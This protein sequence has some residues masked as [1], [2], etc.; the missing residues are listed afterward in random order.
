[1]LLDSVDVF[2]EVVNAQSFSR[3]AARLGIPATT[4]S[5]RIR[6][7]EE[8]LGTALLHRTTRRLSLTDAG[9]RYFAHCAQAIDLVQQAERAVATTLEEPRGRLRITAPADLAQTVLVPVIAAYQARY[10]AVEID[11]LVSNHYRDLVGEGIDLAI[12]VGE[13]RSSSLIVRRFF[14]SALGLWAAPDYLARQPGLH[15][16]ADLTQQKLV[17]MRTNRRDIV[18]RDGAE[19]FA[20]DSMPGNLQLDDML[21]CQAFAEGGLGIAL[22]PLFCQTSVGD[23]AR[24]VRVLPHVQTEEFPVNFLYPRQNLVPPTVRAF[25]DL[26]IRTQRDD[27]RMRPAAA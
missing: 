24:L 1:M 13:L 3:A 8:R 18:L 15:S 23:A 14:T 27:K 11:L 19:Q 22:L 25:I 16:L 5:A 2:V 26:A 20:P 7:L 17:R 10:P 12:R 4:V 9:E 21:T 6:R